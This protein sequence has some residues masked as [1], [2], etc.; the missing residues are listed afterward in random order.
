MW[1][2]TGLD[3]GYSAGA[4]LTVGSVTP[5]MID[6]VVGG[7]AVVVGGAWVV[8]GGACVVVGGACV[9]VGGCVVVV[10]GG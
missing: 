1:R 6:C 4:G 10:V 8:V 2:D 9:V 5:V 3:G 7:T